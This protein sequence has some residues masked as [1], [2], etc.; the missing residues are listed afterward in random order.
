MS[1]LDDIFLPLVEDAINAGHPATGTKTIVV[2]G[3]EVLVPEKPEEDKDDDAD[4]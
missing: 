2:D 4:G 3:V 1:L